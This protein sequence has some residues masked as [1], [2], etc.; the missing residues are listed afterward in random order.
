MASQWNFAKV[1]TVAMMPLPPAAMKSSEDMRHMVGLSV[2]VQ[3]RSRL[4][5]RCRPTAKDMAAMATRT[6]A[7]QGVMPLMKGLSPM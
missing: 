5:K 1:V 6:R 3:A 2:S 7:C 4:L